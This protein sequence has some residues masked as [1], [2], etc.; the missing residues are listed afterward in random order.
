MNDCSN[1]TPVNFSVIAPDA[2]VKVYTKTEDVGT[3]KLYE[4]LTTDA[5]GQ[6]TLWGPRTT[7]YYFTA[8]KGNKSNIK[9]GYLLLGTYNNQAEVDMSPDPNATVGGLRFADI[10]G[11]MK[12][13][14]S[15]KI[16]YQTIWSDNDL[17]GNSI[18]EK[19][20]YV[21]E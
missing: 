12:L 4:T 19:N 1:W 17:Q 10:N 8:E 21:A 3:D 7:N 11:D 9:N 15:D 6:A 18:F 2:T 20:V 14:A 16:S 13:D 5:N